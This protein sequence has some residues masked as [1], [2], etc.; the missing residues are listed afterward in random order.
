VGSMAAQ[1]SS[2]SGLRPA[3]DAKPMSSSNAMHQLTQDQC[4]KQCTAIAAMHQYWAHC[5]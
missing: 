1:K 4:P 5:T 3:W 2:L